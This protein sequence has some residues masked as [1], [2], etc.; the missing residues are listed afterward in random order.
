MEG[1]VVHP[2][3]EQSRTILARERAVSLRNPHPRG[4]SLRSHAARLL[5]SAGTRLASDDDRAL[6]PRHA[7]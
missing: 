2:F 4:R 5:I 7:L 3:D 1:T 6:S